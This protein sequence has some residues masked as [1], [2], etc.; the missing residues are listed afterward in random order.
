M[1][2]D[3]LWFAGESIETFDTPAVA[4]SL[5]RIGFTPVY[6]KDGYRVFRR[7]E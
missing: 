2:R 7:V 4:D 5:A 1:S 6:E 3:A